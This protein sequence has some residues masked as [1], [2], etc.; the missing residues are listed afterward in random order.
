MKAVSI[1]EANTDLHRLSA[2]AEAGRH[3]R[4]DRRIGGCGSYPCDLDRAR[5]VGHGS[6]ADRL[7]GPPGRRSD[8]CAGRRRRPPPVGA[9]RHHL[10]AGA[11]GDPGGPHPGQQVEVGLVLGQHHRPS[12]SP[13]MA[14]RRSAST[15]SRSGSPLATRRGRRQ[16]ATCRTRRRSVRWLRAGR[17]CC[18]RLQRPARLLHLVGPHRRLRAEPLTIR[19]GCSSSPGLPVGAAQWGCTTAPAPATATPQVAAGRGSGPFPQRVGDRTDAGGRDL[20]EHQ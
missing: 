5:Y 12:G 3:R 6:R 4:S 7:W 1:T 20:A 15:C 8:P 9:R 11:A 18:G 2:R 17:L 19:L 14:W 16:Q 13:A 10:L